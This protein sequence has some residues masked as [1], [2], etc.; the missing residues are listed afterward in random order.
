MFSHKLVISIHSVH[1]N[2]D[3]SQIRTTVV[4]SKGVLRE[5]PLY[6]SPEKRMHLRI[7]RNP[8]N[9]L[10]FCLK[11]LLTSIIAYSMTHI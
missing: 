8:S 6:I 5:I 3:T 1:C 11:L 2:Q 10:F 9:I 4:K 7:D